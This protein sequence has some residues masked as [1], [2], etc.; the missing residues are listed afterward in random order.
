MPLEL[1]HGIVNLLQDLDY[2]EIQEIWHLRLP[3]AVLQDRSDPMVYLTE[4]EFIQRYRLSKDGVRD[5]LEEI[6]PYLGRIRD[7]R[8]HTSYSLQDRQP[9]GTLPKAESNVTSRCTSTIHLVVGQ[10]RRV[11]TNHH[12]LS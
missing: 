11:D 2:E 6:T 1:F 7:G 9:P 10:P 12:H 4:E 3:R 5:V 8:A